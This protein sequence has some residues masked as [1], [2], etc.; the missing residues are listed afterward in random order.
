MCVCVCG[1]IDCGLKSLGAMLSCPGAKPKHISQ[2]AIRNLITALNCSLSASLLLSAL[3]PLLFPPSSLSLAPLLKTVYQSNLTLASLSFSAFISCCS[4]LSFFL[5]LAG[6]AETPAGA[7]VFLSAPWG[8][9]KG[10]SQRV[11]IVPDIHCAT[12]YNKDSSA[13]SIVHLTFF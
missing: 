10:P 13:V 5:A 8:E 7:A 2:G 12:G 3:F 9:K 4:F 6:W 1:D 11:L